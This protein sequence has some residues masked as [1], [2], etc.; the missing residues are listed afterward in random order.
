VIKIEIGLSHPDPICHDFMSTIDLYAILGEIEEVPT[1]ANGDTH[2]M[3]DLH[4]GNDSERQKQHYY[5]LKE[6][7]N[8]EIKM[9]T[10]P[11]VFY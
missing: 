1:W 4:R 6:F 10:N 9:F 5:R 11:K 3:I 2:D 8:K 7:L